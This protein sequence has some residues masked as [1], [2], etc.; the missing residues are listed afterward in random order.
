MLMQTL[1][2]SHMHLGSLVETDV[3]VLDFT[4]E[5]PI[6]EKTL[7]ILP[8][9]M[10]LALEPLDN[11]VEEAVRTKGKFGN[12]ISMTMTKDGFKL[13]DNGRGIPITGESDPLKEGCVMALT[14]LG[15]SGNYLDSS[16]KEVVRMGASIN[17]VGVSLTAL[18][19]KSFQA[20]NTDHYSGKSIEFN[21]VDHHPSLL[22][23][24]AMNPEKYPD[25]D[26][27]SFNELN[28]TAKNVRNSK[29]SGVTVVSKIDFKIFD[30]DSFTS[31]EIEYMRYY[32]T[33]QGIVNNIDFTFN[34]ETLPKY[35]IGKFINKLYPNMKVFGKTNDF[36]IGVRGS[37]S[38]EK[39]S[40]VNGLIGITSTQ[41]DYIAKGVSTALR[42]LIEDENPGLSM[43]PTVVRNF[44]Q[45]Y[46]V[47]NNFPNLAFEGNAKSSVKNS[48]SECK[49]FFGITR[50]GFLMMAEKLMG[51]K[52]VKEKI[53]H[54][55]HA[56]DRQAEEERKRKIDTKVKSNKIDAHKYREATKQKD[57]LIISEGNSAGNAL[58]GI[59]RPEYVGILDTSGKITN[60]IRDNPFIDENIDVEKMNPNLLNIMSALGIEVGKPTDASKLKY[61]RVIIGSD[62]DA[63]GIH[64]TTLLLGMFG[65]LAKNMITSGMLY[66]FITPLYSLEN[67]SGIVTHQFET[68]EEYKKYLESNKIKKG[69]FVKYMKG[70][71]SLRTKDWAFMFKNKKLEDMITRITIEDNHLA[72]MALINALGRDTGFRKEMVQKKYK[73]EQI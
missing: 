20:K 9:L 16:G 53:D 65:K 43:T 51:D 4:A 30:R 14:R 54:I 31:D 39:Y 41:T 48:T 70:L 55:L 47:I 60:I 19:S 32:C 23:E 34:G 73:V 45:F 25:F 18:F 58:A 71:G 49:S 66:R 12:E 68:K 37:E 2:K 28:V 62:A 42:D 17:G 8:G 36:K 38:H 64:I 26:P 67:S 7:T 1:V 3:D 52:I 50:D 35:D 10:K 5:G 29:K 69:H 40:I 56:K 24:M 57:S 61:K 11:S 6:H 27:I 72:S 22:K 44:L 63:D 21:T 33:M 46:V 59:L 15:S 13:S